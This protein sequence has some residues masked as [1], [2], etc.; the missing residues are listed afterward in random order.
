[1]ESGT[2]IGIVLGAVLVGILL[3]IYFAYRRRRHIKRLLIMELLKGYFQGDMPADELAKRIRETAGQHFMRS[4][5]LHSLVIAA[6]QGAMAAIPTHRAPLLENE[7]KLVRL[8]A[9]LRKEFGLTPY[10]HAARVSM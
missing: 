9:A 6:F 10:Y 1:M 7:M 4:A 8:L 3:A 5:E 2:I